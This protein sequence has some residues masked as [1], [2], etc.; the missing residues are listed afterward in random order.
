MKDIISP[1]FKNVP[2]DV[3]L[4]KQNAYDK[5]NFNAMINYYLKVGDQA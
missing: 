3:V 4:A 1:K 2:D 5:F